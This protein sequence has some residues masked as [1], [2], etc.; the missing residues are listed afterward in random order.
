[1]HCWTVLLRAQRLVR[2]FG[3]SVMAKTIILHIWKGQ[4]RAGQDGAGQGRTRPSISTV[5][6]EPKN[7]TNLILVRA[8][9]FGSIEHVCIYV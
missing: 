8:F 6:Y 3:G 2:W 1:M 4:G 7:V 9:D 5:G